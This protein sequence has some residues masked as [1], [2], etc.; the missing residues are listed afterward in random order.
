MQYSRDI[1]YVGY[2]GVEEHKGTDDNQQFVLAEIHVVAMV[3]DVN[4]LG[5]GTFQIVSAF[6]ADF[7]QQG[8]TVFVDEE[9]D[10]DVEFLGSLVV[11]GAVPH[12][13]YETVIILILIVIVFFFV[14]FVFIF[15]LIFV[16]LFIL[17]LILIFAVL[18]LFVVVEDFY[19]FIVC[20]RHTYQNLPTELLSEGVE[21]P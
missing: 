8:G 6:I 3:I 1:L 10:D 20:V 13:K 2:C 14:V 17:V 15:I 18:F 19:I 4:V 16:V 12:L 7:E 21:S 11:I 5:A 9:V